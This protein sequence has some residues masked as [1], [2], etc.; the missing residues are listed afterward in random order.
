MSVTV[1]FLGRLGNNLFQ[2]AIGRIIAEHLG[3]ALECT[4]YRTAIPRSVAGQALDI[5]QSVTLEDA[6]DYFPNTKLHMDGLQHQ[7]PLEAYAVDGMSEWRGQTID[8]P[9]ILRDASS[10]HILL[11][12]WFQRI[13][14]YAPHRDRIRNWFLPQVQ[15][16][17]FKIGPKDVLVNIRRGAD[18]GLNGWILPLSYYTGILSSLPNLGRVYVCGTCID[19]NV[20]AALAK[21][22][23]IYYEGSPLEH[24]SF[25]MRFHRIVLSNSTFAWWAA[26]LSD[27]TEIFAPRISREGVYSFT[28]CGDVDLNMRDNRYHEFTIQDLVPMCVFRRNMEMVVRKCSDEGNFV[29]QDSDGNLHEIGADETNRE[30]F[31]WL[32]QNDQPMTEQELA[33]RYHGS[34]F[35]ETVNTYV[36]RKLLIVDPICLDALQP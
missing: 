1:S 13:E 16:Q 19:S 25:I 4:R 22:N 18:Y 11:Q 33:H 31:I 29:M 7:Y 17:E 9:G 36:K 2:Y 23:P 14:Y 5:G 30:L 28:G 32:L 6:I 24:F 35:G 3:F 20:R 21:Y 27:A 8:I 26:Y 34:R 10:R 15:H 12:G